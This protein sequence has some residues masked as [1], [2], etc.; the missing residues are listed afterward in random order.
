M[1]VL[2]FIL[3]FQVTANID[4]ETETVLHDLVRTTLRG[5]TILHIAHKLD[6]VKYYDRV[7]VMSSGEVVDICSA[8]EYL[9]KA[10]HY[11]QQ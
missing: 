7:V 5:H 4:S 6:S 11:Q 1:F 8:E 3:Q 9:A 10:H 2:I